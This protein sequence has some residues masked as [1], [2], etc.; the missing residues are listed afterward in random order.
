M[1]VIKDIMSGKTRAHLASLD[2]TCLIH[3]EALKPFFVLQDAAAAKGFDLRIASGFRSYERQLLIWNEKVLGKRALLDIASQ[4]L[5]QTSLSE[6]ERVFAILRWS[7]LPGCSRHHWGTDIDI[8]D[9]AA[10]PKDY[11]PELIVSEYELGGPFYELS[12][13]LKSISS[14]FH[15]SIPYSTDT[16]GVAREPWHLSYAPVAK[17]F[18][19]ALDTKYAR[20]VLDLNRLL[21]G[22]TVLDHLDEIFFRFVLNKKVKKF[23]YERISE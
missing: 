21:L 23:K 4:P 10:V 15:F 11:R 6:I 3:A 22:N 17:K 20:S 9:A 16:G 13:W 12:K 8:W 2:S 19:D 14:D 5:D 18:E 1:Q 7:A